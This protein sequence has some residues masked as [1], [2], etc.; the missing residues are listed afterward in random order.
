M[1]I[2]ELAAR[3]G[4]SRRSIRYY[5]QQ[6]LLESRRTDTGWRIYDERAVDRVRNIRE[7]IAAGLTVDDIRAVVPC[8]DLKTEE[9]RNCTDSPD[10]VVE[11]YQRRLGDVERRA[12]ELERYRAEL[13]DRL[14]R[15]RAGRP[16]EPMEELLGTAGPDA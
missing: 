5:E 7:L 12:A 3:T 13:A 6:G 11:V 14:S 15:L 10:G 1:Q 4:A 8:L 16:D 2:G 9:F